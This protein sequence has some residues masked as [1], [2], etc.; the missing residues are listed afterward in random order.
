[1]Y[2]I[3]DRDMSFNK[4]KKIKNDY[5]ITRHILI[6]AVVVFVSFFAFI[7]KSQASITSLNVQGFEFNGSQAFI[8]QTDV[9]TIGFSVNDPTAYSA[10]IYSCLPIGA[11]DREV[12]TG[13]HFVLNSGSA[14]TSL[15]WDSITAP[16]TGGYSAVILW[17][18]SDGYVAEYP[19]HTDGWGGSYILI[20]DTQT[21]IATTTTEQTQF[22]DAVI[23]R[24]LI[25]LLLTFFGVIY[26]FKFTKTT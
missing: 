14:T 7:P 13:S 11:C 21:I 17:D 12:N 16:D 9:V 5:L 6:S 4:I 15:T 3:H 19:I 23:F 8:H 24:G 10:S 1:M 18:I 26:Y 25:I 2:S 22:D 20:E